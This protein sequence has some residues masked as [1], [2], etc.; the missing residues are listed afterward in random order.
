M[1]AL[2]YLAFHFT[3]QHDV[4]F[5]FPPGITVSANRFAHGAD[6]HLTLEQT[7]SF[8]DALTRALHEVGFE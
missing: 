3:P 4:D 5:G 1:V 8:R 6:V 7:R 2:S